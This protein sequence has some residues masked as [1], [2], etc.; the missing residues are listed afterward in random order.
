[1]NHRF[2]AVIFLLIFA[3]CEP[4]PDQLE[5]PQDTLVM[6]L[7]DVH[8]AEGALLS[9]LP[10][11]KDS[12]KILYY[13]QIYEIHGI[14]EEAFEHDVKILKLNPELMEQVYEEVLAELNRKNEALDEKKPEEKK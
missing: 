9:I 5:I 7:A 2:F 4:K 11:E 10:A 1:M 13:Q 14:I 12:L 6:V 8:I 3:S